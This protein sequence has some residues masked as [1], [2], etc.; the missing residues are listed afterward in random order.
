MKKSFSI[1]LFAVL[2]AFTTISAQEQ[3]VII[4]DGTSSQSDLPINRYFNYHASEIIYLQSE[5]EIYGE[6]E[7]LAFYKTEGSTY[8]SINSVSIYLKH[9]QASSLS[10]GTTS[11]DGY[12]LVWSGSFPNNATSGWMEVEFDESFLYNNEDNL[13][14]LIVKGYQSWTSSRPYYAYTT[15]GSSLAR[16][17][18]DDSSI[19]SSSR[20]LVTSND[21]P[22]MRF[23]IFGIEPCQGIPNP[24]EVIVSENTVCAN[25]MLSL[26]LQNQLQESGLS[27]Q[28]QSSLEGEVWLDISD[29][30][31]STYQTSQSEDTYYRCLVSCEDNTAITQS[32]L[33]ETGLCYCTVDFPS[34]IEPITYVEFNE[35]LNQTSNSSSGAVAYEDF[36]HLSTNVIAGQTYTISVRGNT[37]GSYTNHFRVFFDWNQNGDFTDS[38]ESYYIGY[39]YNS[40]GTTTTITQEITIPQTA[41]PGNI[42]M[43]VI[44]LYDADPID[45]CN[46]IGYGQAE[47]YSVNIIE[48]QA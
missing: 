24:G 30:V 10:S 31:T 25:E 33:I 16:R 20:N 17:Y 21:R 42:R 18:S 3:E 39:I 37:Y 45:P 40:D 47:E 1:L 2:F 28:W 5:I 23:G 15:T 9:T 44:K 48:P 22:N 12:T 38:G 35:I 7:K 36:T 13:Q 29:A 26:S 27:Y 41:E 14:V 4:G 8:T 46:E 6:I 34:G 32:V 11:L 43:R 19:W